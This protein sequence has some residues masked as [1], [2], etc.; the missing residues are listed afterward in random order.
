MGKRPHIPEINHLFAAFHY[1]AA[2]HEAAAPRRE[3]IRHF[4]KMLLETQN[5]TLEPLLPF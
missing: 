2:V 5:G 4:E 3:G 1:D